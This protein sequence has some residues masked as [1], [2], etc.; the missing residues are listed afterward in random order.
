M[1]VLSKHPS[2]MRPSHDDPLFDPLACE[3]ELG[4][5]PLRLKQYTFVKELADCFVRQ[6]ASRN[7]YYAHR[8]AMA[9]LGFRLRPRHKHPEDAQH[10]VSFYLIDE[11]VLDLWRPKS[12]CRIINV[13][14]YPI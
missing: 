11:A 8:E 13:I 5:L 7:K 10:D 3:A 1:K 2:L 9:A 12:P 14:P 6:P 4:S